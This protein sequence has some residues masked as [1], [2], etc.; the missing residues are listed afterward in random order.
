MKRVLYLTE[1]RTQ[2]FRPV[3]DPHQRLL[4]H[5][6]H[7]LRCLKSHSQRPDVAPARLITINHAVHLIK[8]SIF[9]VI[10]FGASQLPF[11][12]LATPRLAEPSNLSFYHNYSPLYTRKSWPQLHLG[13]SQLYLIYHY[14][15]QGEDTPQHNSPPLSTSMPQRR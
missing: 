5:I 9:N 8:A 15:M 1:S 10:T 7:T 3:V 13:D 6:H 14:P 4:C 11:F 12:T 2:W